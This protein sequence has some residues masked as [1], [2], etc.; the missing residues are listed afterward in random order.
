[1]SNLERNALPDSGLST[2]ERAFYAR[3]LTLSDLG[4]EGQMRLKSARV[5]VVGAGGLG[6]PLLLYLAAAGVGHIGIV[7]GDV[8]SLS[9]LHRQVLY[10]IDDIGKPKAEIAR[11]RLQSLNPHIKIDIFPNFITNDN[12]L[13]IIKQYD[14]IADG[15]DNFP[16]RYL[17]NDACI[18]ANKV[19]VYASIFKFEGQVSVF[20][21]LL[22]DGT[23]SPNYRDLYPT[24]PA[25]DAVPNCAEAGVLGVLPGIIGCIQA[26]EII[27]IITNIGETL[28]GKLLIF[29]TLE[30][31]S[32]ILKIKKT[33]NNADIKNLI[34]Y[35]SFCSTLLPHKVP[36]IS[37]AQL[38]NL[39]KNNTDFQLIDVREPHEYDQ[40]NLGG[41]LIPLA[42]VAKNLHKISKEKKVVIYC[43]SGKRSKEAVKLIL[44]INS[45]FDIYNLEG[46][47]MAY[48]AFITG[49]E[50]L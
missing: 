12:A 20:N 38:Y 49:S 42:E 48:Q 27:K 10:T 16:T 41:I 29:D 25:P 24:P 35:E 8:I 15:T 31:N 30:M 44:D 23:C 26:N 13:E 40:Y 28:A 1:M 19:N 14:I 36:S 45:G 3:H 22:S 34:D 9:N 2:E 6:S 7:D 47:V 21:Q 17:I 39:Q 18:L 4:L 5:L 37:V 43:Q 33:F 32:H 50:A 11:K 46:G